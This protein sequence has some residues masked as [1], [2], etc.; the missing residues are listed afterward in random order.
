[1]DIYEQIHKP[2]ENLPLQTFLHKRNHTYPNMWF[3]CNN[4]LILN[5]AQDTQRH[6][7]YVTCVQDILYCSTS[8]EK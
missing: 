1:M 6:A 2:Y 3:L 4:M 8:I 5:S 7:P